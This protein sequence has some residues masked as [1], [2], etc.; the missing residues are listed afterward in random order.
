MS[1]EDIVDKRATADIETGEEAFGE[2]AALEAEDAGGGE[3]VECPDAKK[4]KKKSAREQLKE[5]M[6]AANDRL[7]RVMAEYDNYRKRTEKEKKSLVTL[8]TS[9]A[10]ERLLPVLDTL[11]LAAAA[12]SKDK[13]FKKGVENTAAL[14][15]AKLSSLGVSEIEAE[16]ARFDPQIHD[17]V[18][19]EENAEYESGVVIRV[20]QKG[21]KINEQVI[22]L[23][24]VAVSK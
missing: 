23:P 14:F 9:L 15:T 11:E 24:M 13:E 1:R 12:P 3:A 21:Y 17:C 22:R 18:A 6:A 16:G 7:L 8:G 19:S 10:V 4:A 20:M 5:E 2:E